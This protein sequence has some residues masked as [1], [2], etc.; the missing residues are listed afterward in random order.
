MVVLGY[1]HLAGQPN[2]FLPVKL[3]TLGCS[4]EKAMSVLSVCAV[5]VT[6]AAARKDVQ[7]TNSAWYD[8]AAPCLLQ[9]CGNRIKLN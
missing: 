9:I 7:G 6:L 5:A 1:M 8:V 2:E 3:T 4:G